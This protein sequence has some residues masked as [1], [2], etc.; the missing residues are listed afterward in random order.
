MFKLNIAKFYLQIFIFFFG[1]KL[2]KVMLQD[3]I[4]VRLSNT[5][6][7]MQIVVEYTI[8]RWPK[9]SSEWVFMHEKRSWVQKREKTSTSAQAP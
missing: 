7:E 4:F 3:E 1:A 2:K 5:V 6:Q 8:S 9:C